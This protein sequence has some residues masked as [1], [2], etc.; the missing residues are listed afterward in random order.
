[1]RY[2][3]VQI[4][5]LFEIVNGGTPTADDSN[6]DGD[7]AWATPVDLA[8]K[9]GS[10]IRETARTLTDAGLRSG[11]RSVPAASLLV[12]TR[13]PIGYVAQTA[14]PMAFNQ[15]CRGL[16][17]R[18][19]AVARFFNYQLSACAQDLQSLG[20]GS[21]FLELSAEDLGSF[22]VSHPPLTV[23]Q[24]I[25]DYLDAETARIDALIAKK[26]RMIDLL[27]ERWA[28]SVRD[29]L[30]ALTPFVPLKR[31]W[32][33]V[34]CKHRT[35]SYQ[36]SGYP[37]VS[38]GDVSPGRITLARSHRFVGDMDFADLTSGRRRPSRGDVVYSRNASI[39]I[40]C[41][42]DT[43]VPFCMG[44]DVCLITSELNDCLLLAYALNSL[45]VDQLEELK[46]G[47]TFDRVNISQ[48]LGLRV[49]LPPSDEQ[50]SIA[51]GLD[52]RRNRH[53]RTVGQIGSQIDLLVEKRQALITA[54]VTGELD[55]PGAA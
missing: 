18:R 21:T 50:V 45:G 12:S 42:V 10:L 28:V 11:S 2:Q 23:Q 35:P 46:V 44:Q 9:N 24:A 39:G 31:G 20:Q 36:P 51:S 1:M 47:S 34:D 22:H 25:A 16:V 40:A 26:R 52:E 7:F 29:T 8:S 27:N 17:P 32:R 54:V 49:P 6:W 33:V 55:I 5:R 30:R 4:R 38:P 3:K 53:E 37:V 43:N 48:I 15:G 19:A 13:A 41:Y 14:V